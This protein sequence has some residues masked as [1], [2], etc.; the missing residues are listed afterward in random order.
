MLSTRREF[1]AGGLTAA[2][3]AAGSA[4]S[5]ERALSPGRPAR[6]I[7]MGVN[8]VPSR[9]WWYS[10]GDW[11]PDS[12]RRDLE[13]VSS[14]GFDHIRIQL[15]WPE[16]QPNIA[17]VSE[18]KL[19]RLSAFLDLAD[20]AALDVEVTVLDGQL[21]GFL[22][23]PSW[24]VDNGNGKV[25]N[26]ITD[27]ALIEAQQ[28]L[29]DSLGRRIGAHPRFLG[30]D[31]ANEIHWA[32][33]PL[34]LDVTPTQG[35]AW[36]RALIGACDRVAP[37]K[38]HVNG[39]DKYPL[40]DDEQHV[41]TRT[42]LATIGAA[43]VTHPWE[44]FGAVPGGLFKQFG[45]LSTQATHYSEFLI[46]YLQ[47]FASHPARKVWIEEF[48]CSK[49]WV[50][51]RV[52]PEWAEASI[53][54]AASCDG[55]FGLTWWCSHD[56]NQR[57]RG[58]NALEYSLGLFTNDRRRKPIGERLRQIVTSFDAEPPAVMPRP[59]ALVIDDTA[60]AD[61]VV[62]RFMRSI[63]EGVRPK[64]VLRSGSLDRE[65]LRSRGIDEL[66]PE[67][68]TMEHSERSSES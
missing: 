7:R 13:D 48:G 46:Q 38:M 19:D 37:G 42:G 56:P 36:A 55:L 27:P 5:A 51:E 44:G 58:M 47:A 15:L 28:F 45:P 57:F 16:F 3:T 65:Y 18:E 30:F 20:A 2:A 32:T 62:D 12:I 23:I 33:I 1:L 50:D 24:L 21:S 54:N 6:R 41:F 22:F 29:F 40:E 35:D 43:S 31:I 49:Q 60:G 66:I 53:R 10:W 14:L 17:Y 68:P 63:D 4:A 8:Y 11:R 64:I 39:V 25:H 9:C 61:S 52:I 26:F 67:S 59:H 34:G